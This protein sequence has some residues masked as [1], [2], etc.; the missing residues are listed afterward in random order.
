MTRSPDQPAAAANNDWNFSAVYGLGFL[1]I[2]SAFNYLDRSLLG[3]A[4]PAIKREMQVSD[5]MLGL[6][7]GIAFLLLYSLLGIPSSE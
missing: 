7:S 5:T 1:T 6:V 3:L 2:V 4:L